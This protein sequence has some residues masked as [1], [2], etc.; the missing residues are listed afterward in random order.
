[1]KSEM[2]GWN[3]PRM[4]KTGEDGEPM[5]KVCFVMQGASMANSQCKKG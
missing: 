1:M 2:A 5:K 3:C 4:E